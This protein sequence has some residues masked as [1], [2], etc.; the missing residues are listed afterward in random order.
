MTSK[1]ELLKKTDCRS[2]WKAKGIVLSAFVGKIFLVGDFR[3]VV[4]WY[5]SRVIENVGF[6]FRFL[7]IKS[8]NAPSAVPSFF[9]H[10]FCTRGR[11]VRLFLFFCH[12]TVVRCDAN[13]GRWS[14]RR[15]ICREMVAGGGGGM[16]PAQTTRIQRVSTC[17]RRWSDRRV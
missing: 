17:M 5:F 8:K 14:G 9:D 13:K 7:K 2:H 6:Y 16:R 3:F 4:S 15:V 11:A 12:Y 10:I 1:E